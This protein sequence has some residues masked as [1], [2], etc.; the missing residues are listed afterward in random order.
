MSF[1]R[2]VHLFFSVSLS[3]SHSAAVCRRIGF[4]SRA[5]FRVQ[6]PTVRRRDGG[7]ASLLRR[8]EPVHAHVRGLQGT[9]RGNGAQSTGRH[10][11]QTGLV[12]HVHRRSVSGEL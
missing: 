5:V 9:R 12:G 2:V 4:P 3:L 8:G 1:T 6:R 7:L 10:P 11:V